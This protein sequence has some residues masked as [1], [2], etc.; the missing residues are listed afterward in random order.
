MS[1]V[2]ASLRYDDLPED[3]Q[4]T[5]AA[6]LAIE[7][8]KLET[9]EFDDRDIQYDPENLGIAF[10][11]TPPTAKELKALR[12][13]LT[14]K[15]ET[16]SLF[17]LLARGYSGSKDHADLY[18]S[19]VTKTV[20]LAL[21]L[22]DM[23]DEYRDD[24]YVA[25][26]RVWLADEKQSWLF[27]QLSS[28]R[29]P[30]SEIRENILSAAASDDA[31]SDDAVDSL[32]DWASVIQR[33]LDEKAK[34]RRLHL[35]DP[36]S[37]AAEVIRLDDIA[38][39][40]ATIDVVS[41]REEN[42]FP[43]NDRETQHDRSPQKQLARVQPRSTSKDRS[44]G[45]V[46][47]RGQEIVNGLHKRYASSPCL[48]ARLTNY[49]IEKAFAECLKR[50][51]RSTSHLLLLLSM[52]YGRN[53]E[54]LSAIR[55][56]TPKAIAEPG[57]YWIVGRETVALAYQMDLP[58]HEG[59]DFSGSENGNFIVL[60][61]PPR[62]GQY[63]REMLVKGPDESPPVNISGALKDLRKN[64]SQRITALNLQQSLAQSLTSAGIDE[65]IVGWITGTAPEHCAA[66]Y[67]SS[68]EKSHVISVFYDYLESRLSEGEL[69][70]WPM[71]DGI[72]GS[73]LRVPEELVSDLF[74]G[75]ASR[76]ES[77]RKGADIDRLEH[78]NEFVIYTSQILA[79]ASGTR[80]VSEPL[81]KLSGF[82]LDA[83]T[84]RLADKNNRRD[85]AF[86]TVVLGELAIAQAREYNR[87]LGLLAE[88]YSEA[89]PDVAEHARKALEGTASWLFLVG[90]RRIE[91]LRPKLIQRILEYRWRAPLNWPRH[92]LRS[93]LLSRGYDRGTIRSFMGHADTGAAPQNRFDGTSLFEL[94]ALAADLNDLLHSLKIPVVTSWS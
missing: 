33:M 70:R 29:R 76:I 19:M 86:R 43:A 66:L 85:G 52:I 12:K 78:H 94:R 20:Q 65:A 40:G 82:N 75:Q 73:N 68:F 3:V 8:D 2:L 30:F 28:F 21:R 83:G 36:V 55:T 74:Q 77:A 42:T 48:Y 84:L 23:G 71:P 89:R 14:G 49:E 6:L 25:C 72:V 50:S 34:R 24:V 61:L 45:L 63:V 22:A 4:A 87:N 15:R 37:L 13:Q 26:R 39:N 46:G 93:W 91:T 80:A 5:A 18:L 47:L 27:D 9:G 38:E 62:I 54:R 35:G 51:G 11:Y 53:V 31:K 69:K 1:D 16:H 81:G 88:W 67:Y 90:D 41:P 92:F 56:I 17:Y 79:L 59:F 7:I 58:R 64:V 10:N 32:E 60:P 57:D 44:D